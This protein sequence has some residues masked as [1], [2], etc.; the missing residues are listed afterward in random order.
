M[1][2]E[3]RGTTRHDVTYRSWLKY[4]VDPVLVPCRMN[5]ISATGAR[6][7]VQASAEVPDIFVLQLSQTGRTYRPCRVAWRTEDEIG[8][9]FLPA[10]G[11]A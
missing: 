2:R 10:D 9:E 1:Q 4:G 7:S 6:V 8:V 11:T 5:D 3:K